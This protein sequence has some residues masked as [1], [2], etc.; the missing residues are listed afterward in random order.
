MRKFKYN[1][2]K[3]NKAIKT[4]AEQLIAMCQED[5]DVDET[6]EDFWWRVEEYAG[7]VG[8]QITDA[9]DDIAT[10]TGS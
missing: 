7:D 1:E 5:A 4:I 2:Q 9:L 3:Y 8:Q 10:P 6:E